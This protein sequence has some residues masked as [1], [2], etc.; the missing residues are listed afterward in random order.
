MPEKLECIYVTIEGGVVAS[1][2]NA[3]G[4]EVPYL[5]IDYD[6]EEGGECCPVCH[7]E[8]NPDA[9][10]DNTC[11]HCGYSEERD[12]ALACAVKWVEEES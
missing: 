8:R 1:V 9:E 2:C 10:I 6:L 3:A 5:V 7:R 12:N 4:D 11:A